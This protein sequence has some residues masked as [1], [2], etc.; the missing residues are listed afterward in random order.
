MRDRMKQKPRTV[1]SALTTAVMS[2]LGA[3]CLLASLLF[4]TPMHSM[5]H[6]A[7]IPL[8]GMF[9]VY[10]AI[11]VT[12]LGAMN[13]PNSKAVVAILGGLVVTTVVGA[14]LIQLIECRYGAC[15][16]L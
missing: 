8:V 15:I 3:G 9:L 6:V 11:A 10:S 14:V 5:P 16:N 1:A 12:R 4:A 7:F 13:I 2:G